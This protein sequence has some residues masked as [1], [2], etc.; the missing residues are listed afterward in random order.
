MKITRIDIFESKALVFV[1]YAV[2]VIAFLASMAILLGVAVLVWK[3]V[4]SIS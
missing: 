3:L 2:W 4:T 1:F